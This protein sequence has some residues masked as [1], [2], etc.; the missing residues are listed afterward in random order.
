MNIELG[1]LYFI[2]RGLS[3]IL[4]LELDRNGSSNVLKYEIQWSGIFLIKRK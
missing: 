2:I 3:P 1:K 4:L